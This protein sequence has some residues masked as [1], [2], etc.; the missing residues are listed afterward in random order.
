METQSSPMVKEPGNK[1]PFH[2]WAVWCCVALAAFAL[3]AAYF[4][5]RTPGEE[6]SGLS[7]WLPI[8]LIALCPLMHLFMHKG[9][10][11]HT[12]DRDE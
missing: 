5:Y 7:D 3:S 6:G 9:L 11:G 1:K 2:T 4:I 10:G 8:L 12:R